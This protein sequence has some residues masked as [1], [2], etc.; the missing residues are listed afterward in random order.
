MLPERKSVHEYYSHTL[1]ESNGVSVIDLAAQPHTGFNPE[2]LPQKG[3]KISD[4]EG[5]R[6][7]RRDRNY[8]GL[9]VSLHSV[10]LRVPIDELSKPIAQ[11][12]KVELQSRAI[13]RTP[14][15]QFGG[16]TEYEH[17][18]WRGGWD[19]RLM[20]SV[21]ATKIPSDVSGVLGSVSIRRYV[22]EQYGDI[23]YGSVILNTRDVTDRL[24]VKLEN[25]DPVFLDFT[26]EMVL[27]TTYGPGPSVLEELSY[28]EVEKAGVKASFTNEAEQATFNVAAGPMSLKLRLGK[29]LKPDYPQHMFGEA[30]EW[31]TDSG[32]FVGKAPIEAL[33]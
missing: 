9:N 22:L 18:Y 2:K 3:V 5:V 30:E 13:L 7:I 28:D 24:G 10:L 21:T 26:P 8:M 11:P 31:I 25:G 27:A 17:L 29:V 23:S 32:I 16:Y 14:E 20:Q 33:N 4:H 1:P 19:D 12:T 6:Y 15:R